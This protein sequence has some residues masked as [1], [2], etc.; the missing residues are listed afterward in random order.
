ME[1][2]KKGENCNEG[3]LSD[4]RLLKKDMPIQLQFV[5]KTVK[6]SPNY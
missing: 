1:K 2:K 6:N 3:Q 4:C 5:I